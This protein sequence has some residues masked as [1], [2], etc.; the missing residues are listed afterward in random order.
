MSGTAGFQCSSWGKWHDGLPDLGFVEP[1]PIDE[2]S[3]AEREAEVER[4]GD[5]GGPAPLRRRRAFRMSA[6]STFGGGQRGWPFFDWLSNRI[7][8]FPDTLNLEAPVRI[9]AGV[10]GLVEFE[11]T[12][13]PLAARSARGSTWIGSSSC[14]VRHC[15]KATEAACASRSSRAAAAR[16]STWPN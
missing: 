8:G 11:P 2:L 9:R 12:D 6:G 3:A 7:G 10:R 15:A 1:L 5:F 13:H 16:R 4:L 14:W